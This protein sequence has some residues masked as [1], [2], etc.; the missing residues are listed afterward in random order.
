MLRMTSIIESNTLAPFAEKGLGVIDRKKVV[1]IATFYMI[2][3]RQNP[4][5]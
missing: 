1:P 4:V 5:L 3:E 2:G